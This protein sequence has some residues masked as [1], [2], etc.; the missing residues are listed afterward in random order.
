MVIGTWQLSAISCV[1]ELSAILDSLVL[2]RFH[3]RNA[4]C[5]FT[6]RSLTQR[7]I[8]LTGE[9]VMT[10]R[11]FIPA[12]V[13]VPRLPGKLLLLSLFLILPLF[14]QGV[15]AQDAKNNW[16]EAMKINP[17]SK[18][19]IKT[20]TG[21]KFSGKLSTITADSITLSSAKGPGMDVALNREEIAEI[22]KKSGA[23]TASYAALLGGVGLAGGFGIGYGVGEAKEA[24]FAVEY[25]TM[26]FG[27]AVGAVVGAI[28]GSRGEVVYKA[29]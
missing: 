25:P 23:R 18:L 2:W 11:F 28:I 26:A 9:I 15:L 10:T 6:S 27:A 8:D 4:A 12:L 22:R 17:G 5:H 3:A 13:A 24:N 29:Q 1:R 7:P 16:G 14:S 20:K 19:T 21:R